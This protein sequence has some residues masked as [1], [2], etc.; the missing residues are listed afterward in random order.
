VQELLESYVPRFD[1][2][3]HTALPAPDKPTN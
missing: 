1:N 2:E 3:F